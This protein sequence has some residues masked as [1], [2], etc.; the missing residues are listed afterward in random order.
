MLVLVGRLVDCVVAILLVGSFLADGHSVLAVVGRHAHTH[1]V[2]VWD[3][4]H[5]LLGAQVVCP[6]SLAQLAIVGVGRTKL[7]CHLL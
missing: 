3:A 6:A 5:S 1:V 4:E 7:L 2:L